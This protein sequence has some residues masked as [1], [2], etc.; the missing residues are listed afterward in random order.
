MNTVNHQHSNQNEVNEMMKIKEQ[1]EKL[2]QKRI[3]FQGAIQTLKNQSLDLE[4]KINNE[5]NMNLDELIKYI[6][7]EEIR[8]Q[9]EEE[10]IIQEF[11]HIY[12]NELINRHIKIQKPFT[13]ESISNELQNNLI[14]LKS[15]LE[16]QIQSLEK[17]QESLRET[18]KNEF[19]I[20]LNQLDG[21]I[22]QKNSDMRNLEQQI[23]MMYAELMED[24]EIRALIQ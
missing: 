21:F 8:L 12:D 3:Q 14:P 10:S 24:E 1:I 20:D 19:N 7:T 16:G 4:N 15:Q 9:K 17:Q 23:Q 6:S 11:N 13:I 22:Q 2:N 18:F 5:Y